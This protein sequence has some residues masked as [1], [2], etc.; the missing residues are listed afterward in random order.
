MIEVHPFGV[1][2]PEKASYLFLGTFTA[3]ITDPSYDWFFASKRNQY[4]TIMSEVYGINLKTKEQ[5]QQLFTDINMAITDVIWSCERSE[6]TNAD[7]NLINMVFNTQA[8]KEI[9]EKNKIRKIFFSSRG[10]E[11]LFRKE[12]KELIAKHSEIELVTLPS[13]SPRYAAMP[14]SEK[15][16]RYR[17]LLPKLERDWGRDYN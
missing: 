16:K 15:V 9:I 3:K 8:I 12:W 5:K 2:V 1:F 10:A 14:K 4:W 13:S 17:E 7:N 6:G 11:K